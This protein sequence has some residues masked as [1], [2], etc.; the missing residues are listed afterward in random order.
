MTTIDRAAAWRVSKPITRA[1][2]AIITALALAGCET[3]ANILAGGNTGGD[4]TQLAQQPGGAPPQAQKAKFAVAPVFGPPD[5]LSKSLQARIETM[6]EQNRITVAKAPT[7][8][9]EYTLRGYIVAAREKSSTKISYIWDVTDPA[10]KRVNRVSGEEVASGTGGS[11]DTWGSLSPQIIDQIASKTVTSIAT[12]LPTQ[13]PAP[14]AASVPVASAAPTATSPLASST[15]PPS[16][17]QTAAA[18]SVP[19]AAATAPPPAAAA[20]VP[21]GSA[22]GSIGRPGQ[23]MAMVPNVSGAPG[24]GSVALTSA[25]QRE[26]SKSG[27]Q[28]SGAGPT[29]YKVEGAVSVGTAQSGKQSVS[30]D[31]HVKDPTGKKLGTVSQKNE[32]PQGSLDGAWGKT[33]D[34]AAAAAAQGILKLLPQQTA[35]TR[36]N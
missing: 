12:W 6:L 29:T 13:T 32:V 9:S 8:P 28:L 26:L 15:P 18:T 19:P 31:W 34:A 24:D 1:G 27:V 17:L 11:S 20:T 5:A 23:L 21:P 14:A 7:D 16:G 36:T 3:G 33:A 30:I 25:I 22:T 35:A 4:S 10:G 2:L